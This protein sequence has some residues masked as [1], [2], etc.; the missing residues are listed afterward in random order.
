MI[1]ADPAGR[2]AR[3]ALAAEDAGRQRIE[4]TSDAGERDTLMRRVALAHSIA[5]LARALVDGF[6][7]VIGAAVTIR[8]PNA[9]VAGI[10]DH[11]EVTV[12]YPQ[13]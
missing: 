7:P 5:S 11:V 3:R 4:L 13:A 12:E 9:P 10:L 8:K 2:L 1:D 6:E